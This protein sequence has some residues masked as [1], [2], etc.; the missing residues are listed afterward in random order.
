MDLASLCGVAGMGGMV[1]LFAGLI[2]RSSQQTKQR[3]ADI[4]AKGWTHSKRPKGRG[5]V[6]EGQTDD[7]LW[8]LTLIQSN[9]SNNSGSSTQTVWSTPAEPSDDV[10]LAGPKLP[11]ALL[12]L[13][14]GGGVAQMLLKLILG[15][16]AKDLV[17]AVEVTL[18]DPAFHQSFSVVSTNQQAAETLLTD[19]V[20]S[21]LRSSV[22]SAGAAVVLR[23]KNRLE[24]RLK[25]G[26]WTVDEMQE[27]VDLGVRVAA[28]VGYD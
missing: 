5:F 15:D 1:L 12:A 4:E 24:V 11:Q 19:E 14:L 16:E 3:I 25:Q 28:G 8:T 9:Q 27:L 13:G 23:W 6:V 22:S 2:Y 7:V 18:D 21:A 17:G 20:R 26:T 10:V